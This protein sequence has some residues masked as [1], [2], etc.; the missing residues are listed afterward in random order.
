MLVDSQLMLC[1]QKG[2]YNIDNFVSISKM[3]IYKAK[4][5]PTDIFHSQFC[6]FLI[7]TPSRLQD[8]QS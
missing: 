8:T 3:V 1:N 4:K 7:Q 2:Q 6:I 5:E